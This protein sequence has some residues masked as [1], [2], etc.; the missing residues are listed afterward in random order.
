MFVICD[1]K[2]VIQDIATEK[3]NLSRGYE[4]PGFKLYENVN[5]GNGMVGDT[6]VDGQ[7]Y[8]DIDILNDR[9]IQQERRLMIDDEI[10][11]IAIDKLKSEGKLPP[12][13]TEV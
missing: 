5:I 9:Q 7:L 8:I 6:Y 3:N 1:D 12:D 4:Y 13:Y 2:N 10:R 11:R